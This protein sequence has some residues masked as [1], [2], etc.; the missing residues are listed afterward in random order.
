M[1]QIRIE[2]GHPA[3]GTLKIRGSKNA[4]PKVMVAALLSDQPCTLTNIS[5]IRD[6]TVVAELIEALGGTVVIEDDEIRIHARELREIDGPTFS[7]FHSQS[8]IPILAC[9]PILHRGGIARIVAPGG[10]EIGPRPINFHLDVLGAFGARIET[11]G[12]DR[13]ISAPKGLRGA[14]VSLPFPSVGATEQFLL[15]S[16]GASGDSELIN[17]AIEPEVLDLV[18]ALQKMGALITIHPN[19]SI[20]V[21]GTTALGGFHHKIIPDRLEAG[22]WASLALATDG[23]ITLDGVRQSDLSTF[24]NYFRR[25]GGESDISAD[26]TSITF[27]RSGDLLRPLALETDVHPG[28]MTDW[29][30]PF[31]TALTQAEGVTVLHETVYEDRLGYTR[32]L[33]AL[34]ANIQV[35]TECLGPKACRFGRSN[36]R[37]SA[38]IVGPAKLTG[39]ELTVPDLR[40]G[41][42]YVIAAAAASGVS[43]IHG[44]DLLDRGYENFRDKLATVGLHV[45]GD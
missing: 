1:S 30:S 19:R 33:E 36:H 41:F 44:I 20:T 29:Q 43:T 12:T 9:G 42:S 28:F 21:T 22:S 10:C 8:R 14:K 3:H 6:T 32:A 31:V 40:G 24:L 35:F 26:G 45:Q 2:G 18:N 25:A 4:L 37:H 27:R 15:T 11:E 23:E 13:V 38:V 7:R 39:T 17:A 16:V 5:K 34:G